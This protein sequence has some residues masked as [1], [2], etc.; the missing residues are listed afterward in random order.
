MQKTS[1]VRKRLGKLPKSLSN[2]YQELYDLNHAEYEPEERKRLNIAL[3]LL[4]DAHRPSDPGIFTKF[5]LWVGEEDEDEYDTDEDERGNADDDSDTDD[6]L[7]DLE[8][9]SDAENAQ[10]FEDND[11]YENFD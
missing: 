10:Y 4:L 6:D 5:V 3:S 7:E 1:D 9:S 2:S 11:D 8:D